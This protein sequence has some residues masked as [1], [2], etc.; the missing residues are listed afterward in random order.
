MSLPPAQAKHRR[1]GDADVADLRRGETGQ[2]HLG[3]WCR[4]TSAPANG[5]VTVARTERGA[6]TIF[7][8][9]GAALIG[10]SRRFPAS[11]AHQ[12]PVGR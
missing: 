2:M 8:R 5:I 12:L 9:R 4:R 3:S 11:G 1:D 7:V 10:V 6:G